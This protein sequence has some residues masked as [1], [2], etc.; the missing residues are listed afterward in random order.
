MIRPALLWLIYAGLCA[1]F[2]GITF[3]I[4]YEYSAVF[5]T[6]FSG[7][8]ALF[9]AAA[10]LAIRR[11]RRARGRRPWPE[12]FTVLIVQLA[13]Y[14]FLYGASPFC[15]LRVAVIAEGILWLVA[16]AT[17]AGEER[18]GRAARWLIRRWK[19]VLAAACALIAL[20]V[21]ARAAIPFAR[22]QLAAARQNRGEFAGAAEAF[23]ALGG[24]RDAAERARAARFEQAKALN[25]SGDAKGAYALLA[26]LADSE[27]ARAYA[28]ADADLAALF[29]ACAPFDVG[30][31]VALGSHE[32]APLTWRVLAQQGS[33]RL[34]L[35]EQI[36]ARMP[37]HDALDIVYWETC[38][39][40]RWLNDSF[41]NEAF[42]DAERAKIVETAVANEDNLEFRT[43][44]GN[45]T[46]D[47]VFLL[48]LSEAEQL[49]DGHRDWLRASDAWWLRSPGCSRVDAVV[50]YDT[51]GLNRIGSNVDTERYG[52]RPAMWIDLFAGE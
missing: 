6:A 47:R 44:A 46:V 13:L 26:D 14:A 49:R 37:Y 48:S 7:T 23:E 39:L 52:V 3:A 29:E 22:Y 27:A 24:Y 41:L 4:P 40:R 51:G 12:L 25:E 38:A 36:V 28:A 50:V 15:P 8:A 45:D 5:W 42:T 18:L 34:L 30:N 32:G 2:A 1:A 17:I 20:A 35:S 16:A 11:Q 31:V 10:V 43:D 19:R 33:R 21:A 9:V